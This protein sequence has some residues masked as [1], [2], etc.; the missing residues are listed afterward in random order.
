MTHSGQLLIIAPDSF[1]KITIQT[2]EFNV[3]LADQKQKS[4][5]IDSLEELPL[6]IS[7]FRIFYRKKNK[8]IFFTAKMILENRIYLSDYI[9][10]P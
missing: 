7:S 6:I 5:I 8:T 2:A 4:C 1:G 3:N 10:R 9:G